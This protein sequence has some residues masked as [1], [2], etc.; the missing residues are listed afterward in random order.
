[1]HELT[2]L[3]IRVPHL[4]CTFTVEFSKLA[5]RANARPEDRARQKELFTVLMA[6][7]SQ[8]RMALIHPLLPGGRELTIR[9]S[10]SRREMVSKCSKDLKLQCVCCKRFPT[11]AVPDKASESMSE[12]EIA[13]ALAD[14]GG[15]G[16]DEQLQDENF[17]NGGQQKKNPKQKKQ[18]EKLVPLDS[19][20]CYALNECKHYAHESCIQE[21]MKNCDDELK[22]P[23]CK[24]LEI[25]MR[26]AENA[27]DV[28]HET[29]C[30]HIDFGP[31]SRGIK[32]TGKCIDDSQIHSFLLH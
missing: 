31:Y 27:D 8:M 30:E 9:F 6:T 2:Y 26:I 29:Y 18:N 32:A 15:T 16:E 19:D 12:Q 20:I 25:R 17:G 11:Q 10:P 7:M 13:S 1:M 24:D 5:D 23:R 4:L 22:C 3:A 28:P 21:L 14:G